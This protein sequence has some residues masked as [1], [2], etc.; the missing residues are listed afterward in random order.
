MLNRQ[1]TQRPIN[2]L[3]IKLFLFDPIR[4]VMNMAAS[5]S[6]YVLLEMNAEYAPV[7]VYDK[8][9]LAKSALE[10]LDGPGFINHF[11]LNTLPKSPDDIDQLFD[12]DDDVPA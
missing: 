9:S 4:N 7:G 10:S 12:I 5:K 6:I 3:Y 1:R 8:L 2:F 11:I